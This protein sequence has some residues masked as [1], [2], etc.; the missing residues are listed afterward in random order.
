MSI[1]TRVFLLQIVMTITILASIFFFHHFADNLEGQF[2]LLEYQTIPTVIE[3]DAMHVAELGIFA[4]TNRI[5]L[6]RQI[7][8]HQKMTREP[9][10][11][12]RAISPSE[13][14][15]IYELQ[16]KIED[17]QKALK[18]YG[19]L[20]AR[21]FPDETVF[22]DTA[23][24]E[25]NRLISLSNTLLDRQGVPEGTAFAREIE[26]KFEY[27]KHQLENSIL[28]AEKNEL[29]EIN[30][31][32]ENLEEMIH[33][34]NIY[35]WG[36]GFIVIAI[37]VL[38]SFFISRSIIKPIQHLARA[39]SRLSQGVFDVDLQ[40]DR[41]DE[42]GSLTKLFQEM[43]E[44]RARVEA[45]IQEQL[46]FL[47]VLMDAMPYP[48]FYKNME[49]RYMGCN[50]KFSEYVG[51]D[52]E[53][54]EG[55]MTSD[56]ISKADAL[57]ADHTDSELLAT[58]GVQ[59]YESQLSRKD[60]AIR[61][62]LFHKATFAS[63]DGTTLGLV[64]SII[65]ISDKK[66]AERELLEARDKADS[67]SK[68]KST[69]LATMSHEI[70]TPL[71]AI[72]GLNEHLLEDEPDIQRR[73]YL[74]IAKD[75]GENLLA[76]IS[77]ILDLS[78]IEAEQLD[79]ESIA[80]DLPELIHQIVR[81]FQPRAQKK[82]LGL[83]VQMAPTI[84]VY[85]MGDPQRLRQIF[86]NLLGN[87]IKFTEHGEVMVTVE[88]GEGEAI[89]FLVSDSGIGI[90]LEKQEVIFQPFIQADTSTTRRVGG[91]GL[92]L[93]ICQRLITMMGGC[94]EVKSEVGK[95]SRFR[96]TI[97]LPEAVEQ[98]GHVE[99]ISAKLDNA[100]TH[101]HPIRILLAEDTEENAIVVRAFLKSTP[102]QLDVVEDGV[103]AV[104][105]I[106]SGNYD[107]LLLD[108]EM[109]I[110]DGFTAA[111]AIRKWEK[112]QSLKPI[113][114]VALTAHAFQEVSDKAIEAG[115]DAH[116]TKPV[117]KKR[118][119]ETIHHFAAVGDS[120]TFVARMHT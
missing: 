22:L 56:I 53:Y 74:E 27:V 31:H 70:R 102:H 23:S 17:F 77:D 5:L 37:G 101:V 114:I 98:I 60:G 57:V 91:T 81:M 39:T 88:R 92:G 116:I 45:A 40:T 25:G 9:G 90:P 44:K 86:L 120:D 76:L 109:P 95:G 94:I 48:V 16:S 97:Q 85:V 73:R 117:R 46:H 61:D 118:L 3:L 19:I 49:Q 96:F 63:S 10:T 58:G 18:R 110:M 21:Y 82:G 1:W 112:E 64:G 87:A 20:V 36:A 33:W 15:E 8:D 83:V 105:R 108:I 78:K 106:Q 107:L 80:F 29:R 84:P 41:S 111:R 66:Q 47:R 14:H 104:A 54:I 30:E 50:R 2:D 4:A 99:R 65:D 68:A 113:P 13:V 115:C 52:R 26:E 55:K 67:S 28:D 35:A 43:V 93:N 51:Y 42:I 71:N 11:H 24:E 89:H 62:V 79:L 38:V 32:H 6:M 103:Q 7:S 12:N 75:A 72:I 59:I 119:L 100:A 69:F 34:I